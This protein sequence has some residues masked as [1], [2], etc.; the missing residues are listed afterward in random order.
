MRPRISGEENFWDTYRGP[1]R[2]AFEVLLDIW[3]QE[4]MPWYL[5]SHP[6]KNYLQAVH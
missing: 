4:F 6:P 5:I 3:P 2:R 1:S